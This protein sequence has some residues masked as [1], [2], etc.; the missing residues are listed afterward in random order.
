MARK[1][2]RDPLRYTAN[3]TGL[4]MAVCL[5]VTA[6]LRALA[7]LLLQLFHEGATLAD[8]IAVPEW[9]L[10]VLNLLLPAA[11]TGAA[12]WLMCTALRK[13][14]TRP[15]LSCSLPRDKHIWLFL[16]VFLGAG[17][18]GNLLTALL[19]RLLAACTRYT[20]PAQLRLPQSG[21]ALLLYFIGVCAVPAVLEE[22]WMRGAVQAALSRWGAWFS[23]IASSV[24][25]A[26]LHGDV[27]QM[28][29]LF[30]L[31][32][33]LGLAA[34]CTGNPGFGAALHFANN[35]MSFL[36]LWAGQRMDGI[37]ALAFSGYLVAVFG[38]GAIVCAVLIGRLGVLRRFRPIPRV[39]DPKNRQS[40]FERMACAPL[41]LGVM[42]FL[43]VRAVWP[44][45]AG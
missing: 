9:V 31:S 7:G 35:T 39:Y 37:S 18:L 2:Q 34:H 43:A 15:R 32:V 41:F 45:F 5:G 17:F 27:A 21:F 16:P 38:I 20:P 36:F 14:P 4:S 11:G 6:V 3:L 12:L 26:L 19:Q 8:P 44:L 33:F 13:T 28:P 42:L 40:R 25:C 29:S 1:K 22:L 24:M 10:G 23:I 30:F